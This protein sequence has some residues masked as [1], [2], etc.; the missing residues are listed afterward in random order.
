M[1]RPEKSAA[2]IAFID[3]VRVLLEPVRSAEPPIISGSAGIRLSSANSQAVRVAISFGLAARLS[4]TAR[5]AW[6]NACFGSSPRMR[7]SNSA[8]SYTHLRAHETVLD[9][10]CRL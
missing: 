4:F 7:C 3:L 2:E 1:K 5:T 9:L 8:V 6:L 10:V